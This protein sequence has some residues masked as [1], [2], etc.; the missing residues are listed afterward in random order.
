MLGLVRISMFVIVVSV[1]GFVMV[2]IIT[3]VFVLVLVIIVLGF[4]LIFMFGGM[5]DCA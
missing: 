5:F 3:S 2:V 1:F 4:V